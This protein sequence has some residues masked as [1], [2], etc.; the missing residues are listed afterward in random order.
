MS[1][2]LISRLLLGL[3]V[4]VSAGCASGTAIVTGTARSPIFPGEVKLY[5]QPPKE[6][7]IIGLVHASSDAGWT[8]QGAMDYAV[9]ELKV[10]AAKLGANGVLL[11]STGEETT[12]IV[13]GPGYA[14]PVTAKTVQGQ[15]IFVRQQHQ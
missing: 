4:L 11:V 8:D 5:L 2:R 12:S 9:Q 1:F 15:A 13:T 3:A 6:F 7:E 14:I 10:Q